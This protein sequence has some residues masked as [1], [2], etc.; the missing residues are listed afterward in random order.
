METDKIAT[1][2]SSILE[3]SNHAQQVLSVTPLSGGANNRVFKI[4]SDSGRFLF[5]SYYHDENDPK[6]RATT[7]FNFCTF[8]WKHGI[9]FVPEPLGISAQDH[10]AL[11]EFI[12]GRRLTPSEI[13]PSIIDQAIA[14]FVQLNQ[15][16]SDLEATQ[17]P[18]AAEACFSLEEHFS[19]IQKRMNKLQT[20]EENQYLGAEAKQFV[21][22]QILPQWKM[23]I[24]NIDLTDPQLLTQEERC[25]SPSDFGFHNSLLQADSTLR[26]FDFE[27]A[28]W[29]DPAKMICDFFCQ[30]DLP[31]PESAFA[32]F[33]SLTTENFPFPE[34]TT[35]RAKKLFPFYRIKWCC[36][37]LNEFLP[38]SASRRHFA[39]TSVSEQERKEQQLRKVQSML[40]TLEK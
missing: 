16:R 39:L 34:K 33:C 35:H 19:C 29:D 37:L 14:F 12:E 4:E 24:E 26:F 5:K 9:H 6:D 40:A 20:I 32:G 13:T 25:L 3:K 7:D 1:I 2:A 15:H 18:A 22:D 27:Y 8:A 36:I 23:L 11:Y 10:A 21:Y 31:V 28:G 38:H 17:I 30:P